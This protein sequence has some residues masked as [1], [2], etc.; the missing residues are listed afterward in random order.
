MT[1]AADA[2]D[3]ALGEGVVSADPEVRALALMARQVGDALSA[4]RLGELD[5]VRILARATALARRR[6]ALHQVV[7][8]ARPAALG[9]AGV[10][11][12]AVV[13]LVV[14]RARRQRL[15]PAA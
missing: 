15:A 3:A 1:G 10:A 5:R 13:S 4:S 11:L 12:A 7:S 8:G 14:V 9:A 6:R 2:L